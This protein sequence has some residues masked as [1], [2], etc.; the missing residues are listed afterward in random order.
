MSRR[1]AAPKSQPQ[2]FPSVFALN[3]VR[4]HRWRYLR[5]K[6]THYNGFRSGIESQPSKTRQFLLQRAITTQFCTPM[7]NQFSLQNISKILLIKQVH[8]TLPHLSV[9]YMHRCPPGSCQ[10]RHDN[11]ALG[12]VSCIVFRHFTT[13]V[14]GAAWCRRNTR[15]EARITVLD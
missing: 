7:G 5:S 6:P 14:A 2:Q 10:S 11:G 12:F 9:A 15:E 3:R 4:K 8:P 13:P 1:L